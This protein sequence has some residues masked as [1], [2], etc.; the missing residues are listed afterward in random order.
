[1]VSEFYGISEDL[2]MGE[3]RVEDI[4]KAR[5][6]SVYITKILTPLTLAKI[7]E[8]Y[9]NKG[10]DTMINSCTVVKHGKLTKYVTESEIFEII[11]LIGQDINT[12]KQ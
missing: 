11:K 7:G 10:H 8:Y 6:V 9:G 2:I 1:M 5:H 4:M 12:I 3:S